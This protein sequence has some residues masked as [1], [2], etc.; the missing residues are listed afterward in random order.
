MVAEEE[1]EEEECGGSTECTGDEFTAVEMD[2]IP[3]MMMELIADVAGEGVLFAEVGAGEVG[4]CRADEEDPD[5]NINDDDDDDD[6]EEEGKKIFPLL[7]LL[8]KFA[9][10]VL[11]LVKPIDPSKGAINT[12]CWFC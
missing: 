8:F 10:F 5:V 6:E 1:G 4:V 7:L 12:C 2:A 11:M 3:G 9:L